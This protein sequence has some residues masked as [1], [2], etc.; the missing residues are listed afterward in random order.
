MAHLHRLNPAVAEANRRRAGL[1]T[2]LRGKTYEEIYGT[3]KAAELR[4]QRRKSGSQRKATRGKTYEE[5][6]GETKAAELKLLRARNFS[7]PS[8]F[9]GRTYEDI[10][11]TERAKNLRERRGIKG[12]ANNL[13]VHGLYEPLERGEDWEP[14]RKNILKRDKYTCQDCH[15]KGRLLDVHH[16]IP[17]RI[18]PKNLPQLLI[19]LCRKCHARWDASWRRSGNFTFA[20]PFT[21]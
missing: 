9:K 5:I 3:V 8:H 14:I 17:Y 11:G 20:C 7:K 16:V 1:P 6:Y 2:K 13:W 10:Y 18:F 12:P 21:I 19:T 4:E 15:G